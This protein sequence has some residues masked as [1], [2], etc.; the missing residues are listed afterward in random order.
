MKT[1]GRICTYV[2]AGLA[3]VFLCVGTF[4]ILAILIGA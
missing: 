2:V 1:F 4:V 3:G